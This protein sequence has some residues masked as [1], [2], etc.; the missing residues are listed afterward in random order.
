MKA[1]SLRYDLSII[2]VVADG[3]RE[4]SVEL[5]QFLITYVDRDDNVYETRKRRCE[6][7]LSVYGRKTYSSG[8]N[9]LAGRTHSH[10]MTGLVNLVKCG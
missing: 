6:I 2:K 9:Q 10:R 5:W 7:H 3:A 1:F 8:G 4:L